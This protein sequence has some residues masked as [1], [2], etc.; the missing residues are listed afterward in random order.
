MRVTVSFFRK[1]AGGTLVDTLSTGYVFRKIAVILS[2]EL[3]KKGNKSIRRKQ[4][5]R[6]LL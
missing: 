3:K 5:V 1:Y 2:P 6:G 4:I